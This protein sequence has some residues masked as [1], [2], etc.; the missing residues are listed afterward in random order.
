M[1]LGFLLFGLFTIAGCIL[2]DVDE[3]APQESV[4]ATI[5]LSSSCS[6]LWKHYTDELQLINDDEANWGTHDDNAVQ[7][8]SQFSD[9]C[10]VADTRE[11][12]ATDLRCKAL[13][14]IYVNESGRMTK[15]DR[16]WRDHDLQQVEAMNRIRNNCNSTACKFLPG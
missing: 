16:M 15:D 3:E 10:N 7:Y 6:D 12:A 5:A 14:G 2:F 8:L 11:S 13:W 9:S 1:R 4:P